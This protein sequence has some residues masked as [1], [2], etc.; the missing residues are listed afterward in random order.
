[1]CGYNLL[2][3][4]QIEQKKMSWLFGYRNSQPPSDFSQFVPP[5]GS[6]GSGGGDKDDNSPPKKMTKSQM[7][8]YMFD[9][10]ALERAASAAKELERSSNFSFSLDFSQKILRALRKRLECI[11]SLL[12]HYFTGRTF[13]KIQ[14]VV[15]SKE[16]TNS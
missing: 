6:G 1:M 13:Y 8:A 4:T 15:F 9:S 11:I 2:Q 12:H 3:S 7:D 16:I 14:S 5:V 10:A